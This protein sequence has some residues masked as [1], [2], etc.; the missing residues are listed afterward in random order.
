M[1]VFKLMIPAIKVAV[2]SPFNKQTTHA[3]YMCQTCHL[4]YKYSVDIIN[5]YILNNFNLKIVL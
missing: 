5:E 2:N 4:V 1:W 3:I